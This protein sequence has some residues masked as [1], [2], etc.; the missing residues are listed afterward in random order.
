MTRRLASV[1]LVCLALPIL[2]GA[3]VR[4]ATRYQ[5]RRLS[6]VLD[7]L[8]GQGLVLVYSSAVVGNDLVVTVEPEPGDPREILRHILPPLGLAAEDG[9]G[10]SLVV[11]PRLEDPDVPLRHTRMTTRIVVTPGRHALVE[12]PSEAVRA[13]DPTDVL[14]VPTIGGDVSRRVER[15]PGIAAADNSSAFHPRGSVARDTALVLDGL[16]LA[17]PYHLVDFQAPFTLIDSELAD[18]VELSNGGFAAE[19]GDRHGA[20]LDVTTLAP[21]ERRGEVELG[22]LNSRGSWGAPIG[23]SG[24]S[25]LASVRGWYPEAFLD[26]LELG[27]GER[28]RPRFADAYVK[29]TWPLST[30]SVLSAHALLA[31][32]RLSWQEQGETDNEDVDADATSG[33]LWLRLLSTFSAGTITQTVVSGEW[34]DRR[35]EG[36]AAPDSGLVLL[37]DHREATRLTLAHDLRR[38]LSAA[39]LLKA[40]FSL[41]RVR[42]DYAYAVDHEEDPAASFAFS[43]DPGET[44]W[45]AWLACRAQLGSEVAGEIGVRWDRHGTTDDDRVGPRAHLV[46]R[47]D[48]ASEL[49]LSVGRYSQSQRAEELQVEDR[50]TAFRPPEI[51]R[52]IDA[53]YRRELPRGIHLRVDAYD[54]HVSDLRPRYENLFQ[55]LDLFP[56]TSEDRVEIAATSASLR[57]VELLLSGDPR[58]TVYWWVGYT[59]AWAE[60]GIDGTSVPRSWDQPHAGTAL[61]GYQEPGGWSASIAALVHTGW[62]T[63]PVE[64]V[65]V[66]QP[67]GSIEVETSLGPRNSTRVPGYARLDLKVRKAFATRRGRFSMTLDVLNAT[68]R[69]NVC[70]VDEFELGPAAPG[71]VEVD[72]AYTPWIGI[73]PTFQVRWEF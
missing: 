44:S 63:T 56:E 17:A 64:A 69:E 30:R 11:V 21:A 72:P 40:G 31:S 57:G 10:G 20:F 32:E 9:P 55:P 27:A 16:E 47:P 37:D 15:L 58:R 65:G 19:R 42:T 28:L 52:Q 8:R 54:H 35:R 4:G 3:D 71:P 34:T 51:A 53:S 62:P 25:W 68:D 43:G 50:E 46:W 29:G 48:D 41:R 38:P 1:C 66:P 70:C 45:A 24:A 39:A 49:R 7:E 5:G 22:T 73:T 59:R 6:E 26:T 60:D 12:E 36:T 13:I 2:D 18:A 14:R 23:A 67:D 61:V 33:Y